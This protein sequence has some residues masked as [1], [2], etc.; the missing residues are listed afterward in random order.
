MGVE[1]NNFLWIPKIFESIHNVLSSVWDVKTVREQRK[2]Y[3]RRN[4]YRRRQKIRIGVAKRIGVEKK[5]YW[6]RPKFEK[7]KTKIAKTKKTQN[8]NFESTKILKKL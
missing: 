1:S 3:W 4:T 6:R 5:M 7:R 2:Q 8:H